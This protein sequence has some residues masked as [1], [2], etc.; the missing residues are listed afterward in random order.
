MLLEQGAMYH[1]SCGDIFQAGWSTSSH[2]K[3]RKQ[4]ITDRVY[5]SLGL[6]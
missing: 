1:A 6:C 4:E 2:L 3:Q 5:H